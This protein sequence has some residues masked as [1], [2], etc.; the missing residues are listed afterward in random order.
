MSKLAQ[1]TEYAQ[2]IQLLPTFKPL[3][4]SVF[5]ALSS[6]KEEYEAL[7]DFFVESSVRIKAGVYKGLIAQG[8]PAEHALVLAVGKSDAI[9][10]KAINSVKSN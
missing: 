4:G 9:L 5:E 2:L 3:V 6:Y 10:N 1:V 8:I 7:Q